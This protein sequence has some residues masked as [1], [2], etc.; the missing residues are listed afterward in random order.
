MTTAVTVAEV[1]RGY[2]NGRH[3][4]LRQ[5]L[6]ALDV[7]SVSRAHGEAA[8]ELL[9]DAG[10]ERH[11]VPDAVLVIAAQRRTADVISYD[12]GDIWLLASYAGVPAYPVA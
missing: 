12:Q 10:M 9:A 7:V 8:G 2:G 5:I 11:H 1:W 6:S 3:W 4:E